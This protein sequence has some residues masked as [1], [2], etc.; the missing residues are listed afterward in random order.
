MSQNEANGVKQKGKKRLFEYVGLRWK[1]FLSLAIFIIFALIVIWLFQVRLLSFFYQNIKRNELKRVADVIET[2]IDDE[3]LDTVAYQ[4]AVDYGVCLR[5]MRI[6]GNT[7]YEEVSVDVVEDCVLHHITN[8]YL[9]V[10]YQN[11][12]KS[13]GEYIERN[14]RAELYEAGFYLP[15]FYLSPNYGKV[16]WADMEVESNIFIRLTENKDGKLFAIMLNAEMTPMVAVTKMLSMQFVWI[17]IVLL[18]GALL[19]AFVI[20]K[21]ISAPIERMNRSAKRLAQGNYDVD[22][23]GEGFRETRELGD[24]LNYAAA[25]LSKTDRLQKE[26]IANISHDLRTPL[27]MITG[28]SEVMRDIPG[29]NT[30]ENV[31]VIIDEANRLSELV[32]ALLD[33]SKLQAGS[34][35]L[36]IS[37]FDLTATVKDAMHRYSKLTEHYGYRIEFY[38]DCT[39]MVDADR[40]MLLQVLY[41][42]INNAINYIGEDKLVMVSQTVKDGHVRIAVTDHGEGIAPDQ[43]AYIWDRYYKVDKVHR[44]ATVGTGIGLSIVKGVLESHGAAYGVDSTVGVGSTFWFEM[45]IAS[46]AEQNN[47]Q[48]DQ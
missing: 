26:L 15:P 16:A 38:S 2:Y 4:Y 41:N 1:L 33:L 42:L 5:I 13:E 22:F 45:P 6:E 27:T 48:G 29:E 47:Y 31:Q 21:Y 24:T 7:A 20:S 40:S 14:T 36:D 12:L 9:S 44:R 17:A 35:R 25:E 37:R 32:S 34:G 19:L 46:E 28:Y 39:V 10:L 23:S 8:D 43:L 11:A 30:P 18:C 3:S